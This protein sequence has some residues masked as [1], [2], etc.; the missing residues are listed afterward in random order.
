MKKK[1]LEAVGRQTNARQ[2][3]LELAIWMS[4][5]KMKYMYLKVCVDVI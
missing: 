3:L 4:Y 1:S 5:K 2:R